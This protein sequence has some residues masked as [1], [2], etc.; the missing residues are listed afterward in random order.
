M[1]NE[2]SELPVEVMKK[3]LTLRNALRE[4]YIALFNL[5][6]PSTSTE[7]ADVV[8]HHRAYV[9]MRLVQLIDLGLVKEVDTSQR[10]K[11]YEVVV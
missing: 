9:N 6:K 2:M 8:K 10:H 3:A 7:V 11:L 5:G 4:T 1:C